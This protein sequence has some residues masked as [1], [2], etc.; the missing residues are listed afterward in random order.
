MKDDKRRID[1][2]VAKT[3]PTTVG[4]KVASVLASMKTSFATQAASF[5]AKEI[6]IQSV[7]NGE[8]DVPTILYPFYLNFGRELWGLSSRGITGPGL[9]AM[10]ASLKVKYT[11]YGLDA[12]VISK[13]ALDVFAVTV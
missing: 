5:V 6:A 10:S 11:S 1:T 13:V 4:L 3:V 8:G 2:Y 9:T 12:A 7:L